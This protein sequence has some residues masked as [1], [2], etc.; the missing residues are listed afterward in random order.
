MTDAP[1]PMCGI[2]MPISATDGL[3]EAHWSEVR[4][5]IEAA[6][7]AVGFEARLVSQSDEMGIIQKRIVENLYSNE[8]VVCDVSGK[9]PNVMF[10]LGMRLA[11]DKPTVVIKDD[12][13]DY[14]FD[15]SPIE[16]VPYRRDLRHKAVETFKVELSKKVQA[17][18][19]GNGAQSFLKSFGSFT[20]PHIETKEVGVTEY[21]LEEI[22][23]LRA[24]VEAST[25][26]AQSV[27]VMQRSNGLRYLQLTP[28][29][30]ANA[31]RPRNAFANDGPEAEDS[32]A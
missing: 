13:T 31:V 4:E 25:R 9:N 2:V 32:G 1:R 3:P 10:E 17:T 14:S 16:H 28:N 29:M 24:A 12:A 8:L 30:L 15:T 11:F 20:V 23:S 19:A 6:V 22:K 21:L 18:Y 7:G 27:E 26:H 5:L